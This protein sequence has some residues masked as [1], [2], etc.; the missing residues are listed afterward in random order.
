MMRLA[1]TIRLIDLIMVRNP[2]ELNI[3]ELIEGLELSMQLGFSKSSDKHLIAA[4]K[5]SKIKA[6]RRDG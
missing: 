5:A 2:Y 3:D 1:M 4:L 6:D